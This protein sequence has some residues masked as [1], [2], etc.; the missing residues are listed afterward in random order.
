MCWDSTD[1]PAWRW[2]FCRVCAYLWRRSSGA[3]TKRFIDG[4]RG[5]ADQ[6]WIY[7]DPGRHGMAEHGEAFVITRTTIQ[8]LNPTATL[9][10]LVL[11]IPTPQSLVVNV[12]QDVHAEV[13]RPQLIRDASL[14][15]RQLRKMGLALAS[16]GHESV[17]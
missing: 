13:P 16:R 1:G 15:L 9:V 5:P 8:H 11:E 7:L 6:S 4:H 2:A 14:M 12:L 10:W 3:A 17:S